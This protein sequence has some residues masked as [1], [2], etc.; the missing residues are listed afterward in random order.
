MNSAGE[1]KA[2]APKTKKSTSKA[3]DA[4]SAK[5]DVVVPEKEKKT[6]KTKK[7]A[8]KTKKAEPSASGTKAKAKKEKKSTTEKK[9]PAKAATESQSTVPAAG[10]A[11]ITEIK[12]E[13]V[14]AAKGS[15]DTKEAVAAAKSAA[16]A[17]REAAAA[18][19]EAASHPAPIGS[20]YASAVKEG[21][22]VPDLLE[23]RSHATG[24]IY[25][26]AV[27]SGAVPEHPDLDERSSIVLTQEG[28]PVQIAEDTNAQ[29]TGPQAEEEH[30]AEVPSEEA[31]HRELTDTGSMPTFGRQGKKVKKAP[32]KRVKP[33]VKARKQ[34]AFGR[35]VARVLQWPPFRFI[36]GFLYT[37]G[38]AA[39]CRLV[40]SWRFL[41]DTVI[42][43]FQFLVWIFGGIFGA[44]GRFFWGLL[45]DL[46]EPFVRFR[47]GMANMRQVAA[48]EREKGGGSPSKAAFRYFGSGIKVHG[49]LLGNIV[50]F[51]MPLAAVAVLF[52]VV[53]SVALDSS[54]ALA[55][56]VEG[57]TIGYITDETVLEDAK[58]MLRG[59]LRLA[60]DQNM[61]DWKF[62]STLTIART[63]SFT[64]K[65][66]LVNAMLR[67]SAV[68]IV[69]G[70]GLYVDGDLVA[71][72]TEGERLEEYLDSMLKS[73]ED[74]S[75]PDA[76]VSFVNNVECD[77]SL[78]DVFLESSV[79]QY[80]ELIEELS[81]TVSEELRYTTK[82]GDTL[83]SI[84]RNHNILFETLIARNPQ[85]EG[86]DVEYEPGEGE[87]LLIRR[88]QPF[89]QVQTTVRHVSTEPIPFPVVEQE[90][91]TKAKGYRRA[92]QAGQ[93]GLQEVQE[94]Y[95][96][97]DGE[98]VDMV[99]VDELTRVI[100]EPVEEI[101]QIGTF[102]FSDRELRDYNDAYMWP[103][104][105]YTYSSRGMSAGHRGRDINGPEGTPIYAANAGI[106]ITSG[107]HYSYGNHIV[108]QHPDGLLTLYGHCSYLE[109]QE[110][111]AVQQGQYIAN[112]GNTGFSFG[113]H[114]HLEF[115][116]QGGGLL[117]PDDFVVAPH[118][119][120]PG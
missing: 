115:Q 71:V 67:N 81:R 80:D 9:K 22:L 55:V 109:A 79:K 23:M 83:G 58:T 98:L 119:Y 39:E 27:Q 94:D 20:I 75:M 96:Y 112:V 25:A 52:F 108:I 41:R 26:A 16:A 63:N 88:A 3:A 42:F 7:T 114:L 69:E 11:K 47:Q 31:A 18:K 36:G 66:Q 118:G 34:T 113:N 4:L 62:D 70:T 99:R 57:Q 117:N 10:K 21:E 102:D 110:G 8:A 85:F 76:V 65:D 89:L 100:E 111:D 48:E 73:H 12:E 61:E 45:R 37:L 6:T 104:P 120:G 29:E 91:D 68:D 103:V 51:L 35:L 93:D 82:E 116:Q 2:G 97:I 14:V 44:I 107:W 60:G 64:S 19:R 50:A 53:K 105:D 46:A 5:A 24:G 59:R 17:K 78:D 74:A 43:I 15:G 87:E 86:R 1:E 101:I 92:V 72:T 90:T 38:F 54:Y 95:V 40:Q 33:L 77:P 13:K 28:A 49:H 32:K 84:A 30:E 106:V 56:T